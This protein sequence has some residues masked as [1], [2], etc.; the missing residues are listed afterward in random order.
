MNINTLSAIFAIAAL[1]SLQADGM[2][3]PETAVK[4]GDGQVFLHINNQTN[5]NYSDPL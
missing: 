2:V 5:K 1:L 3:K 4:V